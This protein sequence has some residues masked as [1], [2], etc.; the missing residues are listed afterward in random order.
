LDRIITLRDT[1]YYSHSCN[2]TNTLM[3]YEGSIRAGKMRAK[4]Y[5]NVAYVDGYIDGHLYLMASDDQRGEWPIYYVFG[6]EDI[7][8]TYDEFKAALLLAPKLHKRAHA[9][10]EKLVSKLGEGIGFHH[11]PI[12]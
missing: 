7:L 11:P 8:Q 9:S 2:V 5:G 12:L 1:G 6:N 10:A 3:T 4:E